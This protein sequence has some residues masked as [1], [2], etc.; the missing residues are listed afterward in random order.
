MS[1][2]KVN[3]II[4]VG[5]VP[6]GGGGGI[7]QVKQIVKTDTF[8]YTGST[9][10][11][12]T[13][14]SVAITPTS[15]SS[16]ILVLYDLCWGTSDGHVSMRLMRGSTMIKVGDA[17]SN[18]TR[19]TGHWHD[20]GDQSG[21]KYDIV[22]HAGTILDSPATTSSVTYKIMVGTNDSTNN[23]CVNRSGNDSDANWEGRT[24]SA[25]TLMEVSA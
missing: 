10:V 14:L 19:C 21:D 17:A 25:I 20:G 9:F 8:S 24:A 15:T 7:I 2:L 12:V 6:T 5:G 13:G 16:K 23:V 1:T 4:P 11:D 22:Q 18:R 3:S